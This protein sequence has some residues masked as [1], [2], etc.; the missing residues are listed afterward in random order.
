MLDCRIQSSLLWY[1][2]SCCWSLP[3]IQCDVRSHRS[4]KYNLN[5]CTVRCFNVCRSRRRFYV[6]VDTQWCDITIRST[7]E[8]RRVTEC[9]R[10]RYDG[11][12]FQKY[13]RYREEHNTEYRTRTKN[14]TEAQKKNLF[15][16]TIY[17]CFSILSTRF[18]LN[19]CRRNVMKQTEK[20]L[21]QWCDEHKSEARLLLLLLLFTNLSFSKSSPV[22]HAKNV[23]A[24]V[25]LLL[26]FIL[27]IY[28]SLV[29]S[30]V[31]DFVIHCLLWCRSR[32]PSFTLENKTHY[33]VTECG[34][35]V[36]T[37]WCVCV[38]LCARISQ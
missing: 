3:I 5:K 2:T 6:S 32:N 21:E 18:E 1:W 26:I 31:T 8:R 33:Y 13:F 15:Y 30:L 17:I 12:L 34:C 10:E 14:W 27:F 7:K 35:C 29:N 16:Y 25:L 19:T 11:K 20:P 28:E 38:W 22:A 4:H 23:R 24:F 36:P 37:S 9:A